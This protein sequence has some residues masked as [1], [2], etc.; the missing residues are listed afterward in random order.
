M[1][2]VQPNSTI[3]L[4]HINGL[5]NRYMHTL[6][7]ANVEAQNTF[8]Q[9]KIVNHEGIVLNNHSYQRAGSGAIK[10]KKPY[11]EVY[12]YNYMRF[13]NTPV[14]VEKP[15]YV[16]PL[17]PKSVYSTK[18]YYAFITGIDYVNENTTLIT[19]QID[20]M[21]TWFVGATCNPCMVEREHSNTDAWAE[22]LEDEPV[23]SEIYDA[24]DGVY[25]DPHLSG[26]ALV[27][28]TTGVNRQ[29]ITAPDQVLSN[30]S[31][32]GLSEGLFNGA[33]TTA[34]DLS[35]ATITE[36]EN[37]CNAIARVIWEEIKGDWNTS[38]TPI[39]VLNMKMFPSGY[40]DGTNQSFDVAVGR[41][42][43]HYT[44]SIS[45]PTTFDN[46][47]PQNKKMFTYPYSFLVGTTGDGDSQMLKWEYFD[48]AQSAPI[49]IDSYGCSVGNGEIIYVPHDYN[50]VE[51]NLDC[52]LT[53]NNFPMCP[54]SYD[55]YQAWLAA[56][57]DTKAKTERNF[58]IASS[59][60]N[61]VSGALGAGRTV[62]LDYNSRYN[63]NYN[64]YVQNATTNYNYQKK[65]LNKGAM[66]A[67]GVGAANFAG[68]NTPAVSALGMLAAAPQAM[69]IAG[70]GLE[71][72]ESITKCNYEFKDAKYQPRVIVGQ[73]TSG[74]MV[75]NNLLTAKFY[76]MHVRDSEAKRIDEFF[77]MYGY[78]TNRVKVPNFT[79]RT[80]WNFVKT[81]GASIRGN[82]PAT[83]MSAICDILD[84]GINFW[85]GDY[86]GNYS[87]G[88]GNN[89]PV[90]K[91]PISP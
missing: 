20:V 46:F 91:N 14:I 53:I 19:Y 74:A 23:G 70:S 9:N 57:G 41:T 11:D 69:R 72:A 7:F 55:A 86:I 52:K 45:K 17:H 83:A 77:T 31:Y 12:N 33:W 2:Y 18:W 75:A 34:F 65:N 3:Q 39:Q 40:V 85:H 24:S 73:S 1:G 5:D 50:G 37:K 44:H 10:I 28:T 35:G 29:V 90:I 79:G 67:V 78:A 8:M 4:L 87:V 76:N 66:A 27:V 64:D 48:G 6:Y 30:T 59:V 36:I 21:Q 22:N 25:T 58:A 89:D 61:A 84:G 42:A 26:Y 60:V 56:G 82:M 63:S 49:R 62:A 51:E 16:D 47:T 32:A 15:P 71:I 38:E 88:K 81:N 68:A 80:Y 43:K 54:F 13:Q